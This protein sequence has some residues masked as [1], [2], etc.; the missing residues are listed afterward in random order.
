[1]S[2]FVEER[3]SQIR[4]S[5]SVPEPPPRPAVP[6]L[7]G[8]ESTQEKISMIQSYINKFEYNYTGKPYVRLSRT[9]LKSLGMLHITMSAQK[10]ICE[11]LPIQCVEAVFIGCVLTA[12][13]PNLVRV[14]LSFKSKMGSTVH[15]HI[16]LA[17]QL[18][19]KWGAIGIS[20]RDTLMDKPIAYE[21]L[22]DL[23]SEYRDCYSACSHSLL[24]VYLGFPFSNNC[25]SDA[26][27]KWRAV[28]IKISQQSHANIQ[29]E[30]EYY[31]GR[32]VELQAG[33][34]IGEKSSRR[35]PAH[36]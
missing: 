15:R 3:I 36:R 17:L 34:E 28:N 14:P 35:R 29:Q 2:H 27:I 18:D 10:I 12:H 11:S 33:F 9:K 8:F 1:M 25:Y 13:I 22:A 19:G 24:K 5:V 26:P 23:I 21:S 31:L 4:R 7:F 20:R 6:D 32:M 30:T 16:V